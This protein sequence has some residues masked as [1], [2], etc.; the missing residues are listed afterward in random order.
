LPKRRITAR[1]LALFVLAIVGSTLTDATALAG[2]G[3]GAASGDITFGAPTS[4]SQIQGGPAHLGVLAGSTAGAPAPP[5]R[6]AWRFDPEG[7]T[8]LS[9]P[10]AFGD[11][12][13]TLS[14]TSVYAVD[15]STGQ[16][17]WSVTRESAPL[18]PP[19]LAVPDGG[20]GQSLLLYG[21]GRGAETT[22]VALG[23]ESRKQQWSVPLQ[24]DSVG[25]VTVSDGTAYV[26]DF[27]GTVYAIDI[28]SGKVVWQKAVLGRGEIRSAPTVADS[29]VVY[30]FRAEKDTKFS[31]VALDASSGEEAWAVQVG[32]FGSSS[33]G[34]TAVDGRFF[35]AVGV[36]PGNGDV[37]GLDPATGKV[38]TDT[39]LRVSVFPVS[40]LA[41]A[42]GVVYASDYAA[43]LYAID[44]SQGGRRWDFQVSGTG[45]FFSAPV[46]AG[47]SVVTG[48]QDGRLV[49]VDTTSG[50]QVWSG[51]TGPG[52]VKALAAT[53]DLLIAAKGDDAGAL[54]DIA[55]PTTMRPGLVVAGYLA[56]LLL[57]AGA[58]LL[59]GRLFGD[60][61]WAWAGTPGEDLEDLETGDGE[62][63]AD[64]AEED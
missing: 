52:V 18:S 57:L 22:V 37:Y 56:A 40:W 62:D 39:R 51:E 5:Y 23:I 7:A 20:D 60:R 45:Q 1:L 15:A 32:P 28:A 16:A 55:S 33:S 27:S 41:S 4:W 44:A 9:T 25:G 36:F 17:V 54:T 53:P 63:E 34:I 38:V 59:L 24:N 11:V 46:V 48:F 64:E 49:A 12:V 30:P 29:L 19:A 8:G 2:G 26:A 35:L 47:G 3:N 43:G 14:D 42:E 13:F 50:H 6:Q 31:V 10:V 21:E 58:L 61:L